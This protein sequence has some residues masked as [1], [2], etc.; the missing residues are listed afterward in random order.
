[1][2]WL[3]GCL[4]VLAVITLAGCAGAK[5]AAAGQSPEPTWTMKIETADPDPLPTSPPPPIAQPT[6]TPSATSKPPVDCAKLLTVDPRAYWQ[7]QATPP[8]T[9]KQA[10]ELLP[11]ALDQHPASG[12][13]T[14]DG[15]RCHSDNVTYPIVAAY[16]RITCTKGQLAVDLLFVLKST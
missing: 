9:C 2:R 3:R 8:A 10:A 16:D 15:W 6:L 14:V 5:P 4:P 13:Y 12:D 7:E 11:R 1:M